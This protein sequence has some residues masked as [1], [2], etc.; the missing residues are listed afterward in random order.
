MRPKTVFTAEGAE[1]AEETHVRSIDFLRDLR[2]EADFI[3][4]PS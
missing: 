2:G 3:T 1:D 4:R